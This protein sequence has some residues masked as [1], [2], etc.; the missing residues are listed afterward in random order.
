MT[1]LFINSI[2]SLFRKDAGKGEEEQD[3]LNSDPY[4][5]FPMPELYNKMIAV[6]A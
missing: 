4:P 1:V 6:N 3:W 5:G 2:V